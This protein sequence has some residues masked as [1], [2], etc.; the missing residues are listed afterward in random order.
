MES[1]ICTG[2]KVPQINTEQIYQIVQYIEIRKLFNFLGVYRWVKDGHCLKIKHD[3]NTG[4][5]GSSILQHEA[6]HMNMPSR[7]LESRAN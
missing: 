3:G 5:T 6:K 7:D 1:V 4:N 2:V